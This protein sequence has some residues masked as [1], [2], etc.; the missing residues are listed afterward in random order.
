MTFP[1]VLI[2]C[3]IRT[4]NR[5]HDVRNSDGMKRALSQGNKCHRSAL[6]PVNSLI[7]LMTCSIRTANRVYDVLVAVACRGFQEETRFIAAC[8][9]A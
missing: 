7:V 5:A 1:I 8:G 4:A 2:K 9:S 6:K 3:P